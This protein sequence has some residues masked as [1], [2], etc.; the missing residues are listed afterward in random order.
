MDGEGLGELE[1]PTALK[2]P[3]AGLACVEAWF[4]AL[5]TKPSSERGKAV[6]VVVQQVPIPTK[7][8]G[9]P[10]PGGEGGSTGFDSRSWRRIGRIWR[11][12]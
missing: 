5:V 4:P 1:A 10:E 9:V 6:V 2:F 8:L 12:W 11:Q 3:S 7:L